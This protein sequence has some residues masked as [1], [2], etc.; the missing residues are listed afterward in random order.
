[1]EEN[2]KY[3]QLIYTLIGV[4]FFIGTV[5]AV[6][7]A[8]WC[9]KIPR[10]ELIRNV[11]LSGVGVGCIIFCVMQSIIQKELEYNNRNH[12]VRLLVLYFICLAVA[13]CFP[14]LPV[15]G[16]PY[17]VIFIILSL[18]SNS[19]CGILASS[20]LLMMSTLLCTG[21][22]LNSFFLYFVCGSVCA[23]L[24]SRLDENYKFGIPLLISAMVIILC[25]TSNVVLMANERLNIEVFLIPTINV[26]VSLILILI[27]LKVYGTFVVF[28]YRDT[29]LFINDTECPLL[30][31]LK[32]KFPEEYFHAVHV[33]YLSD[34][35]AFRLKMDRNL[36]KTAAY[37]QRIGILK[38]ENTTE[39]RRSCCEEFSFPPQTI[40]LI[41]EIN[42]QSSRPETKEA[43]AVLMA[44]TIVSSIT[45]IFKKNPD[46]KV[47]Y[48]QIIDTVFHMKLDSGMFHNCNITVKEID[49]MCK[50]FTEENLYYDF[51]R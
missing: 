18:F 36:I 32:S 28:E 44:D 9:Y 24:F 7:I 16:W 37:Y 50:I 43:A 6:L 51:L 46:S 20:F 13:L 21:G 30:V 15:A 10:T 8:S 39:N 5:I 49:T 40:L 35:I 11:V 14:L 12:L 41:R 34:K 23:V 38:G 26:V 48:K 42:K 47:D 27:T 4:C 19:F 17:V 29:Y 3:Q 31:E 2:N 1:M 33:A 25:E 45:Y 22:D